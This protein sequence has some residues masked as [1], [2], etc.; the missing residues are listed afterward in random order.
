MEEIKNTTY[1]QNNEIRFIQDPPMSFPLRHEMCTSTFLISPWGQW[2]ELSEWSIS[3]PEATVIKRSLETSGECS[4][5]PDKLKRKLDSVLT[6]A[7]FIDLP[8]VEFNINLFLSRAKDVLWRPPV[9]AHKSPKFAQYLQTKGAKGILTLKVSEA[10]VFAA[11][12]IK[13]IYV[14]NIIVQKEMIVRLVRLAGR[15]DKVCLHVINYYV[16]GN[17]IQQIY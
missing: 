9:K 12:G 2:I 14:A 4:V 10:E 5:Q 6:P 1:Y 3:G 8:T 13:D 16:G 17:I 7:W 15:I 11:N